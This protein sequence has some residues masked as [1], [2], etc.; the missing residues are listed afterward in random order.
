MPGRLMSKLYFALPVTL[1]GPSRRFARVLSTTG[2]DGQAYFFA[3]AVGP[4][5]AGGGAP[6]PSCALATGHPPRCQLTACGHRGF[7]DAHERAAAADVAVES[8]LHLFG[9]RL[10]MLLDQRD[11]GH[12]KARRAEAAHQRVAI[13]E[14]LLHRMQLRTVGQTIHGANLLALHFNRE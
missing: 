2:L 11:G 7:H 3:L 5:G 14:R 1:S 10:W 12:H 4:D 9:R 13:A 6:R 8:F